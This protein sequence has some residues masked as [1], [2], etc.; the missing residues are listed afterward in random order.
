MAAPPPSLSLPLELTGGRAGR[1]RG[2]C[3]VAS[4]AGHARRASTLPTRAEQRAAPPLPGSLPLPT[5][6]WPARWHW[7]RGGC[8]EDGGV[9]EVA[10]GIPLLAAA[11]SPARPGAREAKVEATGRAPWIPGPPLHMRRG[12]V[13]RTARGWLAH[14][15]AEAG[16]PGPPLLLHGRLTRARPDLA[17][18]AGPPRRRP[19]AAPTRVSGSHGRCAA[20]R[21]WARCKHLGPQGMFR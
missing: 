12:E 10:A 1:R 18:M 8:A 16:R 4:R 5:S 6:S 17:A 2:P 19:A 15:A 21:S 20:S 7:R 13:V 11:T 9:K 3:S 14:G